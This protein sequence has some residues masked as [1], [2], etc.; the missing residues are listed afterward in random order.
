MIRRRFI[1]FR[2]QVTSR[3]GIARLRI[4]ALSCC[5][6]L[7]LTGEAT[8]AAT[9]PSG[10]S[11]TLVANGLSNPT[12]MDFAPDGRLFVCLQPG[13]LRVIK[14]GALLPAPFLT[15]TVNSVGERGLLG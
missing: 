7:I 10:F 11:E 13:D 15:V 8:R 9:L 3:T 6:L 12:A 2:A 4:A 14:K 5:L 1:R